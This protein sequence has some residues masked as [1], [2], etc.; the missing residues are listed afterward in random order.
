MRTRLDS[1]VPYASLINV[2]IAPPSYE[3][4]LQADQRVVQTS[5]S[6]N[7]HEGAGTRDVIEYERGGAG[8][9]DQSQ[10]NN[11]ILV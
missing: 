7:D 8:V 6:P 3:D 2:T 1:E 10:T 5:V 4:T 9:E 11:D